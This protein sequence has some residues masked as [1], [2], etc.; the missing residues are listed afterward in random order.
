MKEVLSQRGAEVT[1]EVVSNE[2]EVRIGGDEVQSR[3]EVLIDGRVRRG[4]AVSTTGRVQIEEEVQVGGEVLIGGGVQRGEEVLIEG[5]LRDERALTEGEVPADE[6]VLFDEGHRREESVQIGE[7]KAEV[8]VETE[9]MVT[10]G[11]S[12]QREEN[13]SG[14]IAE[15]GVKAQEADT[16]V[17]RGS[18]EPSCHLQE[19][20]KLPGSS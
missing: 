3:E 11:G 20:E 9:I 19:K 12:V 2:N 15:V 8:E 13:L 6:R 4:D 7:N 16:K 18:A 14:V 1:T 10:V 17:G 5:A